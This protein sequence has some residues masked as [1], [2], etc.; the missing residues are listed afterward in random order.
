MAESGSKSADG[1]GLSASANAE[2]GKENGNGIRNVEGPG[3][4]GASAG[5]S[6]GDNNPGLLDD[7]DRE[8]IGQEVE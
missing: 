7:L 1:A 6:G 4:R 2:L 3:E 8:L 5:G